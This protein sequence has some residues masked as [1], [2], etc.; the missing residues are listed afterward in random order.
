MALAVADFKEVGGVGNSEQGGQTYSAF[1]DTDT[2]ATMMASGYLDIFAYIINV[3]DTVL[4]SGT[5]FSQVV[6]VKTNT[7][8]VVTVA[9]AGVGIVDLAQSLSGPGAADILT[10]TTDVT[11]TGA[12]AVTL[13]D[14]ALGQIKIITLLVDGGTM[15]LTPTN[16]LG[17]ATIVFADLGDS[18]TLQFKA[19]GWAVIG[20][21]GLATGPVVTA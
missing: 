19:G 14:G 9:A 20:Q 10:L 4:L 5:D 16:G 3:R 1:S 15:T 8:T 7:G 17:Y 18:V 6:R 2:L 11:T 13:A 12:D 21:G